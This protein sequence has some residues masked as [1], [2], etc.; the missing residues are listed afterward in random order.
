MD[1]RVF[2]FQ[3]DYT[4]TL[5]FEWSRRAQYKPRI[6]LFAST[7]KAS[8]KESYSIS[9]GDVFRV[10][11]SI[12]F[13]PQPP[14]VLR[15]DMCKAFFLSFSLSLFLSLSLSLSLISM[16][17][18]TRPEIVERTLYMHAPMRP[19]DPLMYFIN[20]IVVKSK[21]QTSLDG[22]RGHAA[23]NWETMV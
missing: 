17:T 13:S 20:C 1:T 23:A 6:S 3:Y 5:R 18:F 11:D 8:K 7:D 4:C 12:S 15:L 9:T 14:L 21:Q 2:A 22:F 16:M 10:T 19:I